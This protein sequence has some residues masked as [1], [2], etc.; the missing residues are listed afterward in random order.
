M[1]SK[2]VRI[3]MINFLYNECMVVFFHVAAR[4]LIYMESKASHEKKEK[5]NF[6]FPVSASTSPTS[7]I[8]S[9]TIKQ[10]PVRYRLSEF[11][12]LKLWKC[13]VQ[14]RVYMEAILVRF[15]ASQRIR[16][17]TCKILHILC[18]RLFRRHQPLS[19]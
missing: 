17:N 16:Y 1:T 9:A 11:Y 7:K 8:P 10:I 18:I 6:Q 14:Q 3:S 13:F 12:E 19:P 4:F 5:K 15:P 2:C